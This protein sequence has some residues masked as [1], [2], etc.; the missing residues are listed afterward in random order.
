MPIKLQATPPP[1]IM[2]F[3][4]Y[5]CLRLLPLLQDLCTHIEAQ[6]TERSV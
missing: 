6:H 4:S 3:R 2:P 5:L 1:E